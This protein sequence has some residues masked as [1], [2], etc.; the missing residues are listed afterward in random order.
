MGPYERA[1]TE[2]ILMWRFFF[3]IN[4]YKQNTQKRMNINLVKQESFLTEHNDLQISFIAQS[5]GVHRLQHPWQVHHL[6]TSSDLLLLT[7]F[8]QNNSETYIFNSH[9]FRQT[10]SYINIQLSHCPGVRAAQLP[11]LGHDFYQLYI[12]TGYWM[13]WHLL[14]VL[15]VLVVS[16]PV[17]LVW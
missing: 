16:Q 4:I 8:Q 5:K 17:V 1:T 12:S 13:M 6:K 10:F 14:C 15:I 2:E 11:H 3:S 7:L 9:T